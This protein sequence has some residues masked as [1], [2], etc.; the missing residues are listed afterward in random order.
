VIK[1]PP[2]QYRNIFSDSPSNKKKLKTTSSIEYTIQTT[3]T[4]TDKSKMV[5]LYD[6]YIQSRDSPIKMHCEY[7]VVCKVN[8]KSFRLAPIVSPTNKTTT[9][10]SFI[11]KETI[12]GRLYALT[13][14]KRT[15]FEDYIAPPTEQKIREDLEMEKWIQEYNDKINTVTLRFISVYDKDGNMTLQKV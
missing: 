13:R 10:K 11:I 3:T 9:G 6:V 8:E 2:F 5:Y 12:Y 7:Y 14:G 4:K 15:Y 1:L